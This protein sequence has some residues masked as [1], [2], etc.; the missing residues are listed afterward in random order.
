MKIQIRLKRSDRE[1]ELL[2]FRL[3][4]GRGV[5]LNHPT[6]EEVDVNELIRCYEC[7]I[8]A[9]MVTSDCVKKKGLRNGNTSLFSLIDE[10]MD[11]MV[12]VYE[13]IKHSP[14][15]L[16]SKTFNERI[17]DYLHPAQSNFDED[18]QL[19]ENRYKNW[20]DRQIE[21]G[22]ISK[23]RY[24]H[25]VVSLK[26]LH[27]F[28]VINKITS[29]TLKEFA[30][31][32]LLK[33]RNF[34]E[35]EYKYV[36]KY[37]QLYVNMDDRQKPA[38]PRSQNTIASKLKFYRTFFNYLWESGEIDK[39]PFVAIGKNNRRTLMREHY[40][41]PIYLRTDELQTIKDAELPMNLQEV[42]DCFLLHC[43][44]GCRIE[45]FRNMSEDNVRLHDNGFM[46]VVYTPAKTKASGFVV[47]TP[48]LRTGAQI[49][50]KY[51]FD[52]ACL[53]NL[54]GT[55]GYNHKIKRIIELSGIDRMV[56]DREDKKLCDATSTKIARKTYI[57]ALQQVQIDQYAAGLH[58]RGSNVVSRYGAADEDLSNKFVLMCAAFGEQPYKT[59]S[60]FEFSE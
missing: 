27:R 40:E 15:L 42:R 56:G 19:L 49:I 52:F 28:L 10:H 32:H 53:R 6:G 2:R 34:L 16:N 1:K 5:E 41:Q 12:H 29:I 20:I 11:A 45:D 18:T 31:S 37:P 57:T 36:G 17:Q 59:D 9:Q 8:S 43:Q 54:W 24:A 3:R 51:H 58:T 30:G 46:Y 39:S 25:Y 35:T 22:L 38:A 21:D 60:T 14:A 23:A 55:E 50:K 7:S 13:S 44:L 48:I 33:L 26:E 4:D 47:K